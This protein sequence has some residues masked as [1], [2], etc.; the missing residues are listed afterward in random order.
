MCTGSKSLSN[1]IL[2]L[3]ALCEGKTTV[4]NLLESEVS[5]MPWYCV[6]QKV[7]SFTPSVADRRLLLCI[8]V[9]R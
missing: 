6:Q 2:L 4:S 1:R 8:S 3:S 9:T 5:H 7:P